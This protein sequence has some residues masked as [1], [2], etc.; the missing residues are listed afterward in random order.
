[1]TIRGKLLLVAT[2]VL[3]A[4]LGLTSFTYFKSNAALNKFLTQAGTEIS[5]HGAQNIKSLLDKSIASLNAATGAVQNAYCIQSD[6]SHEAMTQLMTQLFEKA[7][8]DG[9]LTL[10]FGYESDGRFADGSSWEAPVDFDSRGRP[11]YKAA[12]SAG[13]GSVIFTEPYHTPATNSTVI[14][15]ASAVYGSDGKAV[16]VVGADV[17]L[18]VITNYAINLRIFGSG[19]AAILMENGLAVCHPNEIYSLKANY[20][21]DSDV[22][23]NLRSIMR[24][25]T[26]GETGTA[27]YVNEG[28]ERRTFFAPIGHGFFL[29]LFIPLSFVD[30]V[31]SSFTTIMLI[32]SVIALLL[33]GALLFAVI[34][35][36]THSISNMR[37][38]TDTLSSGDLTVHF[39]D[40]GSDE[41]AVM[42][43]SLN[44]MVTSIGEV[45]TKIHYES[46]TTSH[47]AET[48]AALSEET[49]AS[50]EE[51][52][53]S[54]E[55][56]N[57][58]VGSASSAL[59]RTDA[60]V[61]EIARGAEANAQASTRG[62]EE[63]E[64][65][66]K[67]I[68]DSVDIVGQAVEALAGLQKDAVHNKALVEELNGAV[69]SI[70]GFV[71]VI[72]SIADQTNLLALNAAIEA[73][74]A[75]E[76][77]RGFAVVAE[78]VRKLAEESA[79]AASEVHKLIDELQKHS[80]RSLAATEGIVSSLAF[81]ANA[82]ATQ[83]AELNHSLVDLESLSNAIQDIAAVAREQ[84]ASSH[85]A[86]SEMRGVAEANAEIVASSDA[87]HTST[88]ETTRAAESIATEA[89]KMAETAEAL[90]KLVRTF[91]L[92]DTKALANQ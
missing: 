57:G 18:S 33:I 27:D 88:Q 48:L 87:V 59:T 76:A 28:E 7:R 40:N 45:M 35:G 81:V 52:A 3:V 23:T 24:R 37:A 85:H 64:A 19:A 43:H 39:N 83:G 14:T 68:N 82:A 75:G 20:L 56:V 30:S 5:A 86:A 46:E 50:M 54:M 9:V 74:R 49:L 6:T 84:A 47:Q 73:A 29:Y 25:V 41:L 79:C 55:R 61:E 65:V 67:S 63:A 16:G 26:A 32:V 77:G 62:A 36:V 4:I 60:S 58:L 51:V 22:N 15:I 31:V 42:S 13:R 80:G 92:G 21:T 70:S 71:N 10:F 17:D 72:T 12:L 38:V 8:Q 90:Q 34:R 2:A 11:W 1:M 44:A 53:A 78:E 66:H 91:K 69:E 89:Q